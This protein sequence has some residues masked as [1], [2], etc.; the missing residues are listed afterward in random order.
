MFNSA[1]IYELAVLKQYVEPL[2][3]GSRGDC[4]EYLEAKR[5]LKSWI[6]SWEL[7]APLV[8]AN[9]LLRSSSEEDASRCSRMVVGRPAAHLQTAVE[10]LNIREAGAH[11]H[12]EEVSHREGGHGLHH[13][14]G[15]GD[16]DRV[17]PAPDGELQVVSLPVHR[18]L[19]PGDGG[20]GLTAARRMTVLPSLIPP[21]VPPAWF[22]RLWH[23]AVVRVE[24]VVVPAP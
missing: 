12:Q 23:A 8:P 14:N 20:V 13:H 18:V 17:V 2:L 24:G 16:D 4:P 9:S 15:P 11:A 21:R 10:I 3:F 5:L 22:V 6:I 19:L 1:L 7:K